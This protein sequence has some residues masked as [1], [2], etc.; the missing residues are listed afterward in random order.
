MGNFN[1]IW[2]VR[3]RFFLLLLSCI[4]TGI[5]HGRVLPYPTGSDDKH[6]SIE[7]LNQH[8]DYINASVHASRW[9]QQSLMIY[10]ALSN[11]YAGADISDP[12]SNANLYFAPD[13]F[14]IPL[15]QYNK[16]IQESHNLAPAFRV[17]LLNQ[18]QQLMSS[19]KGLDT[20]QRELGVYVNAQTY[21]KDNLLASI[22]ILQTF[23]QKY[24]ALDKSILAYYKLIQQTHDLMGIAR[25]GSGWDTLLRALSQGIVSNQEL[26]IAAKL[27]YTQLENIAQVLNT[28]PQ[29]QYLNKLLANQGVYFADAM[30]AENLNIELYQNFCTYT[31][32]LIKKV[33]TTKEPLYGNHLLYEQLVLTYNE[34]VNFY[35]QLVEVATEPYLKHSRQMYLYR[36]VPPQAT[37]GSQP[38]PILETPLSWVSMEGYAPNNII[39]LLDLSASMNIYEKWPLLKQ[40]FRNLIPVMRSEDRLTIITF[41]TEAKRVLGPISMKEQTSIL[42]TLE[43]LKPVGTSNFEKGMEM[44][45]LSATQSFTPEANNR[46]IV[47]TDGAFDV[48]SNLLKLAKEKAR[49]GI[50]LSIFNVGKKIEYKSDLYKL[51]DLGAGNFEHITA[52]NA[53][54]KLIKEVQAKKVE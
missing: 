43:S 31:D 52:F 20:L 30:L 8:V 34:I 36:Y 48:P 2:L 29:E 42:R 41:S 7:A 6:A 39:L 33:Q 5:V 51:S 18:A 4:I 35:N 38:E 27:Q 46:I 21:K 28:G 10:N 24:T 26:L 1:E 50:Y 3:N 22:K 32:Q 45:Y 47:A 53:D 16:A 17:Q 12:A 9:L 37:S 40:T 54:V 15:D 19:L 49:E 44:A 14:S 13:N 25:S 23:E 11:Y